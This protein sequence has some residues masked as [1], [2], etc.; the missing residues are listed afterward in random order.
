MIVRSR[1]GGASMNDEVRN[2]YISIYLSSSKLQLSY[3]GA[4]AVMALNRE[5][6]AVLVGGKNSFARWFKTVPSR[7]LGICVVSS[8]KTGLPAK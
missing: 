7:K 8:R 2:D 1:F 6:E 4:V 5:C 3:N